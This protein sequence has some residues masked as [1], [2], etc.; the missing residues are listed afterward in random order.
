MGEWGENNAV[1]QLHIESKS[2][3]V[4]SSPASWS[5][6]SIQLG[7][8]P[9][10]RG[11][12]SRFLSRRHGSSSSPWEGRLGQQMLRGMKQRHIHYTYLLVQFSHLLRLFPQLC[13]GVA[14]GMGKSNSYDNGD[15]HCHWNEVRPAA[16]YV[17]ELE[18]ASPCG[19]MNQRMKCNCS[20]SMA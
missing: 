17:A 20:F 9:A 4:A 2:W 15:E 5:W 8:K 7:E 11:K 16:V 6:R 3:R 10:S 1:I 12:K 14:S 19:I 13:F 18:R